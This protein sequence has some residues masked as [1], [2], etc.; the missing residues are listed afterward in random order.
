MISVDGW[1]CAGLVTTSM[2]H[3]GRGRME[4]GAPRRCVSSGVIFSREFIMV[5][6]EFHSALIP[7]HV[8][9]LY[10]SQRAIG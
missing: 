2:P 4:G 7:T 3:A 9:V 5:I 1:D 10:T 8:V 6:C